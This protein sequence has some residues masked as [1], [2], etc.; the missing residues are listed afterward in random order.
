MTEEEFDAEPWFD[1]D[2][3]FDRAAPP[4]HA[5][6][7]PPSLARRFWIS[8]FTRVALSLAFILVVIATASV[9]VNAWSAK[10][11]L[12]QA[13]ALV[14]VVKSQ[15]SDGDYAA[16]PGTFDQIHRHTAKARS[17][18]GGRLWSMAEHLPKL[19]PNLIT[20]REL[21]AVVDDTMAASEPLVALAPEFSHASLA[22]KDGKVPL[23]PF[24]RAAD[25]LPQF[26]QQLPTLRAQLAAVPTDGA[27][28]QLQD[29][30]SKLME[31]FDKVAPPLDKALPLVKVL[32]VLLGVDGQRNYVVMFQNNAELRSLGGTALSFTE[33]SVDHGAIKLVR[34]VPAGLK[35]FPTHATPVIPVPDGFDAI[36]DKALGRFI[37]N[38]T[39]RP[40][41]ITAAQIIQAEWQAKFGEPVDGVISMDGPALSNLL[42]AVG[43]VTLSTGDVVSSAN[44]VDLLFNQVYQ[45]Y[46]SGDPGADNLQQNVVYAET[47]AKTFAKLTSGGFSPVTLYKSMSSAAAAN[48]F[49]VWLTNAIEQSD[50]ASTAFAATG[51]PESTPTTDMVGMYLNDQVGSKLDYYLDSTV[52]TSS[53][54]CT[55][56]GQQV[57]RVEL[58]LTSTLDPSQ[59]G[60]LSPSITGDGY[61]GLGLAKGEQRYVVFAYL[62][63][64]STLL[65]ASVDGKPVAATGQSDEGHPVQVMW[66]LV[67]PGKTSTVSVDVLMGTPGARELKADFTPTLK[68]T[69]Q[70]TAPLDCSTVKLP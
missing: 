42:A 45:R 55:P 57:N 59:V 36:Y 24:V 12:Q 6:R 35:E 33:I 30:K 64:D 25:V 21:T 19:G 46:N 15:V 50:I 8:P 65:S 17:L 18:M 32:P 67:P 52:T 28:P 31:I 10:S 70:A 26:A 49:T 61:R 23:E 34:A 47:V 38:A 68:G 62:P 29:A 16:I 7:R 37:P 11:H 54:I 9:G 13:E 48:G 53:A 27:V 58:S 20:L 3:E 5:Y 1:A 39:L 14:T 44:V 56:A 43:P 69:K 40:S 63:K 51:L 4:R 22:P 66:T 41:S 2:E 60:G